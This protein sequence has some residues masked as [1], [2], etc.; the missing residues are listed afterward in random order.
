[1]ASGGGTV[2]DMSFVISPIAPERLDTMR[3]A[4]TD[5]AGDRFELLVAHEAGAPLRCCLRESR[6]GERLALIAY[7]PHGTAGAYREIG[8]V[9]VHAEPCEGC[10]LPVR[11]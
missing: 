8:T 11:P 3:D 10:Q 5:D 9:F 1:M 2:E 7:R 6:A 4:G